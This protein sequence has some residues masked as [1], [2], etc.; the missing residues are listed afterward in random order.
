MHAATLMRTLTRHLKSDFLKN[1]ATVATGIASAQAVGFAFTPLITRLY[2]PEAYGLQG[3]F[4]SVTTLLETAAALSYPMAIILP[5]SDTRALALVR[6]SLCVGA[7]VC[8]ITGAVFAI[9]GDRALSA[10][11][12][13]RIAALAMLVPVAMFL[14]V[15]TNVQGNWLIRKKAFALTAKCSVYTAL[16]LNLT[17]VVMGFVSPTAAVLITSNLFGLAFGVLL[18]HIGWRHAKRTLADVQPSDEDP[19]EA[20]SLLATAVAHR[21]FPLLRTPQ[22]LIS[23]F[24]YTLPTLLLATYFGAGAAGQYSLTLAVLTKPAALIGQSVVSVFSPRI[25]EALHKGENAR[26]LIVKATLGLAATMSV[27]VLTLVIAAPPLFGLVFG[28]KWVV[29]GEYARWL[30]GWVFFQC[31]SRPTLSAIPA[32]RLQG[33]LLVYEILSTS[34]KIAALWVGFA[35][36][37]SALVAVAL[38]SI[39]GALAFICLILWVIKRSGGAP[40]EPRS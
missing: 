40:V 37:R 28:E 15:V 16:V 33:G 29:A 11:N 36:F 17:K 5:R 20:T 10:L 7:I 3:V 21:D 4:L 14:S 19:K 38:F 8:L 6:L 34:A 39:L 25:N 9:A 23:A 32:L 31:I 30:S 24:S 26:R 2:G 35:V 27:P 18:T 12:A 22:H 1:V 13:E